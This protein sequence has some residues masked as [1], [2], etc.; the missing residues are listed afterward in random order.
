MVG[1]NA[2]NIASPNIF[3]DEASMEFVITWSSTLAK[4][5]IQAF[6]EEVGTNPRIWYATTRDFKKLSP[7]ALLFDNNYATRD[8][9]ILR[10][11]ARFA[12]LHSDS[13]F[14]VHS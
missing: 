14:P 3:Y 2:L 4:N 5:A 12:L 10:D 9:V 13:T 6:Q 11:G 8:A 1:Q 7:P